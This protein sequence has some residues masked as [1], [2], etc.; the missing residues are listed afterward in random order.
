M[1]KAHYNSCKIWNEGEQA[2][3]VC[4][5]LFYHSFL[6][7]LYLN[8]FSWCWFSKTSV[9]F[10]CIA[11]PVLAVLWFTQLFFEY[12]KSYSFSQT[13]VNFEG[14]EVIFMTLA[15]KGRTVHKRI[16]TYYE[17]FTVWVLLSFLTLSILTFSNL[18]ETNS[19]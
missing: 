19:S 3:F 12:C 15:Q 9:F 1:E 5:I 17:P 10:C 11:I 16:I 13:Q 2:R 7:I 18:S 8:L 4:V 6:T 14:P